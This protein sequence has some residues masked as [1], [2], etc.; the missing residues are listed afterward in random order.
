MRINYDKTVINVIVCVSKNILVKK[1]DWRKECCF[2]EK[3]AGEVYFCFNRKLFTIVVAVSF[4][5]QIVLLSY[6]VSQ[7]ECKSCTSSALNYSFSCFVK[8]SHKFSINS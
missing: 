8:L 1:K 5:L 7:R 6:K 3:H 2:G 4:D